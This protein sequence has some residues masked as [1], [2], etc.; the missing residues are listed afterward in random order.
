M[1]GAGSGKRQGQFPYQTAVRPTQGGG[2]VR[3]EWERG[4][5][6]AGGVYAPLNGLYGLPAQW[7]HQVPFGLNTDGALQPA[8]SA[9]QQM[10]WLSHPAVL[11]DA[12]EEFHWNA[13]IAPMPPRP[14]GDF[15]Y[16]IDA[17]YYAGLI[18]NVSEQ[19]ADPKDAAIGII[20]GESSLLQAGWPGAF[21]FSNT[22]VEA[23]E[24]E[25]APQTWTD[26]NTLA[27]ESLTGVG[28]EGVAVCYLTVLVIKSGANTTYNTFVSGDGIS[29][30]FI[31]TQTI[32]NHNPTH[33]GFAVRATRPLEGDIGLPANG[34]S[35]YIRA[36][37][38]AENLLG[39]VNFGQTGG[40]NW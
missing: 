19:P 23:S 7:S 29:K 14:S 24:M 21:Y 17:C 11:D 4:S 28:S 20:I 9:H 36:R 31:A 18:D 8:L 5:G 39:T 37:P 15:A 22:I 26:G 25:S 38:A 3:E 10:L 40:R 2:I 32:N 6:K 34:W 16:Q 13:A 33:I 12:D 1:S 30:V 27:N 35:N